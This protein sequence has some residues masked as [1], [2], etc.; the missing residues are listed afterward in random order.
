MPTNNNCGKI[1]YLT[2][3]HKI[4]ACL[5]MRVWWEVPR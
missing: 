4:G 1:A 3:M 2:V 5:Q